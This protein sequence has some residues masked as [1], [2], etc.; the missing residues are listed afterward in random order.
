MIDILNPGT[1]HFWK[2]KWVVSFKAT[3]NLYK[4]RFQGCCIF[5]L[6][7][8]W[9]KQNMPL[10]VWFGWETAPELHTRGPIWHFLK[11]CNNLT[12]NWEHTR[13]DLIHYKLNQV[14]LDTLYFGNKPKF[15]RCNTLE[16]L[17]NFRE[18]HCGKWAQETVE[19]HWHRYENWKQKKK[20]AEMHTIH[21]IASQFVVFSP[22]YLWIRYFAAL[23]NIFSKFWVCTTFHITKQIC[24]IEFFA[25]H[26]D[27]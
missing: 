3:M 16:I 26:I 24:F 11:K 15:G 7:F 25:C 14:K 2:G 9:K 10:C 22:V 6:Q 21:T 5:M 23:L 18:C 17:I 12:V 19:L 27:I 4:N 1:S 8:E 20:F 13:D